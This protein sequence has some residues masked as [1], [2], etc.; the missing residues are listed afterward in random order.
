MPESVVFSALRHYEGDRS[1]IAVRIFCG[2][3][4]RNFGHPIR[5]SKY[6]EENALMANYV[7][8][9]YGKQC[10]VGSDIEEGKLDLVELI[11]AQCGAMGVTRKGV[12]NDQVC[13]FGDCDFQENPM[14]WSHRRG[15]KER[16]GVLVLCL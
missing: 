14:W 2:I 12:W 6:A 16:N 9:K 7:S 15:D 13:T 4:G 10:F 8:K 11:T 3:S 5:H 1:E